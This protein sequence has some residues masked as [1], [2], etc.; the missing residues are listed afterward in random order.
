M[1]ARTAAISSRTR[2]ASAHPTYVALLRGVNVGTAKRL[3]MEDFRAL[4]AGLGFTNA[5]T[6]LNSGNAVF[7]GPPAAASSVAARIESA[8]RD[9]LGLSAN[10]VVL[11]GTD[12][13]AIVDGCPKWPHATNLSRLL[14]AVPMT[15]ADL[16]KLAPLAGEAWAPDAFALGTKAAYLWCPAGVIDSPLSQAVGRRLGTRVTVR[17]YSTMARLRAL[18]TA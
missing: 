11:R 10:T 12:L 4:L 9:T 2:G 17:N 13:A 18:I 8:L 16:R 3:A 1:A 6:V 7:D 14:I 5:R 15:V